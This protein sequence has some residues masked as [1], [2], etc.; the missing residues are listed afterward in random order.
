MKG[1]ADDDLM[2]D[3]GTSAAHEF[4]LAEGCHFSQGFAHSPSNLPHSPQIPPE[5][6]KGAGAADMG[7]WQTA[8]RASVSF[9]LLSSCNSKV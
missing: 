1:F 6:G 4:L 9:L 2:G 7:T 5:L 8:V 3:F